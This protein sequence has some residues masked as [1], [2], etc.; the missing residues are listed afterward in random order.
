MNAS[1]VAELRALSFLRR[2]IEEDQLTETAKAQYRHTRL[3]AIDAD[4]ALKDLSLASKF[5]TEWTF[6][7]DLRERGRKAADVWLATH[8]DDVGARSSFDPRELYS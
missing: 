3:H 1:L 2:L 4:H 8:F 7:T 5:N 6:L